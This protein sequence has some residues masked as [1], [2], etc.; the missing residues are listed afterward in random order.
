M[1]FTY[2]LETLESIK[3]RK[4]MYIQP[5]DSMNTLN[6]LLVF[7]LGYY[8]SKGLKPGMWIKITVQFLN[9][10]IGDKE[11]RVQFLT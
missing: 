6:F 5:V 11:E 4:R 9:N 7:R 8:S 3:R 2:M 10:V 1:N